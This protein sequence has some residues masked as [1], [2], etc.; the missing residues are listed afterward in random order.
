[1]PQ[2]LAN[3][4]TTT[5]NGGIT[6]IATSIT[7]ASATG[8]P[9]SAPFRIVVYNT[10]GNVEFME[11][12]AGAGTTTW[13]VTRQVE[14]SSRFPGFAFAS[15]STVGQV[16]TAGV[17]NA[18]FDGTTGHDHSATAGNAPKLKLD[19]MT[20]AY[21]RVQSTDGSHQSIANNTNTAVT[22]GSAVYDPLSMW[23][24]GA[25]TEVVIPTGQA[26]KYAVSISAEW[27]ANTTGMRFFNLEKHNGSAWSTVGVC[28]QHPGNAS[29]GA[30]M[31]PIFPAV[32]MSAGHKFRLIAY[33]DS[34]GSLNIMS[35]SPYSVQLV[36]WRIA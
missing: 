18:F 25:P 1:M 35:N 23:S 14:D 11:V 22:F 24:A 21:C 19:S 10:G 4:A 2:Q 32:D 16:I 26:G 29:F 12:T 17:V 5:L 28:N 9:S 15:G 3:R 27:A 20:L 33:Q 30:R 36:C 13:T 7:V 34:G 6:A 31:A 8:F